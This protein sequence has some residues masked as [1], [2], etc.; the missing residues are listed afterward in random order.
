M[1][2]VDMQEEQTLRLLARLDE[3]TNEVQELRGR[4][5]Q[6]CSHVR[7]P[8]RTAEEHVPYRQPIGKEEDVSEELLTWAGKST[9]L[10]RLSAICFILVV[11]LVLRTVTDHGLL[12]RLPGALL[13]IFY[14]S[15]LIAVG[16]RK[17]RQSS[18]L[19]PVFASCG[20]ILMYII[21]VETQGHFKILPSIPAY[22]L[23]IAA[24]ATMA[25]ISWRFQVDLPILVG[26]L[27]MCLAGLAIEYPNPIF[28]LLAILLLLA[29]V[30][31]TLATRLRRCSWLRWMVLGMTILVAQ[32]WSYKLAILLSRHAQP[33]AAQAL[34]WFIPLVTLLGGALLAIALLGI[35]TSGERKVSRFDLALPTIN[36]AWIFATTHHLLS[37]QSSNLQGFGVT[38]TALAA[39]HFGLAAWLGNARREGAPGT[40]AFS[41][42]GALLLTLSLPLAFNNSLATLPLLAA[43]AFGLAL[44]A[45]SWSSGGVRGTSYLLQLA[46]AVLLMLIMLGEDARPLG[47]GGMMVAALLAMAAFWHFR[48]CRLNAPPAGS[49]LFARDRED[50]SAVLLLLAALLSTF[51]AGRVIL[52]QWLGQ[53]AETAHAFSCAQSVLINSG[54][55]LLLIMAIR[56]KNRELRN[57]AMLI[58]MLGGFKVF[59]YDLLSTQGFPLVVS[60]LSFGLL[61]TLVP[62]I[63][64]RWPKETAPAALQEKA[65][66]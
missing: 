11:A 66:A 18:H 10:P 33:T 6:L 61:I 14:A 57:V 55:A 42:A 23:L 49:Q 4:V 46:A 39:A 58:T 28:P 62:V 52:Y 12:G 13:G 27:G 26:T 25:S 38:M 36:V 63:L 37:V 47:W 40:N 32:V 45:Q 8:D 60:V 64:S 51:M 15:A 35:L 48:W 24:G 22:L 19:A 50:R 9:L 31:A 17:Y 44:L 59:L 29:N 5:D 7:L 20:A 53:G 2:E 34:P 21:V 43:T 41:M 16:W 65:L 30:L 54:A 56:L 1:L 3:L